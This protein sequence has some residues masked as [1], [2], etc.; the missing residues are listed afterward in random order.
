MDRR[1]GAKKMAQ[2]VIVTGVKKSLGK[3]SPKKRGRKKISAS[4]SA[5]SNKSRLEARKRGEFHVSLAVL[6]AS[7]RI[8][9]FQHVR[10]QKNIS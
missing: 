8:R 1:G 5:D 3:A 9:V 4:E 2:A 7:L 10:E 6:R